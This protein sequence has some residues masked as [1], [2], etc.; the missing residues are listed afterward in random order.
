[1]ELCTGIV[2]P[3]WQSINGCG[4]FATCVTNYVRLAVSHG[5]N[6]NRELFFN[7]VHHLV[8]HDLSRSYARF[9]DYQRVGHVPIKFYEFVDHAN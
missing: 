4:S 9:T 5:S 3:V 6:K 2:L 1:M 7:S 8:T